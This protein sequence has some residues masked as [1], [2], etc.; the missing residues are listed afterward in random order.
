[1]YYNDEGSMY[2]VH[3]KDENGKKHSM[4]YYAESKKDALQQFN[5]EKEPGDVMLF[6]KKID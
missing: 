6:V 1:M 4:T 2:E 3:Y 5:A